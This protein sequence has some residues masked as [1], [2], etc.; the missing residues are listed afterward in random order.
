L[1]KDPRD[2]PY[3]TVIRPALDQLHVEAFISQSFE[4][5]DAAK[6]SSHDK[7]VQLD[8]LDSHPEIVSSREDL[9][10]FVAIVDRSNAQLIVIYVP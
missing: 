8:D 5:I 4:L 3:A 1:S 6:P 2:V 9:T 10:Q 7:C